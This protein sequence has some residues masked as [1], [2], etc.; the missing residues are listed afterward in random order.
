MQLSG[1]IYGDTNYQVSA[2]LNGDKVIDQKDLNLLLPNLG[3]NANIY[4]E[5]VNVITFNTSVDNYILTISGSA[6]PDST[7]VCNVYYGGISLSDQEI[8]CDAD[9]NFNAAAI[10]SKTG[11]YHIV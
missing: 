10:L 9:G 8:V 4:N 7:V 1:A 5:N 6:K 2:D 3:K 11:N